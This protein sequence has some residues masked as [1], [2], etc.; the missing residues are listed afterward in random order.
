MILG[1]RAKLMPASLFNDQGNVKQFEA[2][3]GRVD[4]H[5]TGD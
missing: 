1:S 5:N 4:R 2:Y 3:S